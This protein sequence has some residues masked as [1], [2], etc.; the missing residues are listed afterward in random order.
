ML[1]L[2]HCKKNLG[3]KL[4]TGSE[5]CKDY[6]YWHFNAIRLMVYGR[7]DISNLL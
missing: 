6:L 3:S 4:M 7:E 1:I 2:K 5:K